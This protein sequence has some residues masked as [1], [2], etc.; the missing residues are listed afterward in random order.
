MYSGIQSQSAWGLVEMI[1]IDGSA[2][3]MVSSYTIMTEEEKDQQIVNVV[4]EFSSAKEELACLEQ[5][6]DQLVK[7]IGLISQAL[8]GKVDEYIERRQDHFE[9]RSQKESTMVQGT[10]LWP[11]IDEISKVLN[12]IPTIRGRIEE[13]KQRR[14][15]LGID[16]HG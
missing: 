7:A 9:I 3:G 1:S 14:K 16:P 15:R 11:S 8:D 6:R 12:G 10:V 4:K 13:L 5:K 2:L